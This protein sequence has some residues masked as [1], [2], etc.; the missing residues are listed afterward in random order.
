MIKQTDTIIQVFLHDLP[1][2]LR[3]A[4]RDYYR[5]LRE[6]GVPRHSSN[7]LATGYTVAMQDVAK[8][9]GIGNTP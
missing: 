7:L 4:V 5:G 9:L 6:G 8:A 3:Y 1:L 2:D